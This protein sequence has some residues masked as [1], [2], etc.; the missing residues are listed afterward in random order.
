MNYLKQSRIQKKESG[1]ASIVVALILVLV[2]GLVTLGFA[3]LA[4][5]EQQNSLNRQLSDVAYYAAETGLNDAEKNLPALLALGGTNNDCL[6]DS[7]KFPTTPLKS[8][9]DASTGASYTCVRVSN[10]T[11]TIV[12][13]S[14]PANSGWQVNF[15]T[16]ATINSFVFHWKSDNNYATP[17]PLPK[18]FDTLAAWTASQYPGVFQFSITP[19][20]PSGSF[21]RNYLLNNTYHAVFYPSSETGTYDV[22]TAP[23]GALIGAADCDPSSNYQPC[24][25]IKN[26]PAASSYVMH[27]VS[28]YDTSTIT[29]SDPTFNGSVKQFTGQP[30]I[31]VTAKAR[32]VLK[33][34]RVSA[35]TGSL[36]SGATI[37]PGALEASGTCKRLATYSGQ[38]AFVSAYPGDDNPATG[39]NICDLD[40]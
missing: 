30:T 1:F 35:P 23:R 6:N 37:P 29:L 18:K 19:L 16:T 20:P 12:R 38:T 27:V 8:N 21:D 31:D 4:R 10:S 7:S 11:D 14:I 25:T 28:F 40:Y 17:H 33:R 9:I 15:S 2:L 34:I 39:H 26:L 3:Q 24:V 5:R 32:Y 22:A 13:D 36:V